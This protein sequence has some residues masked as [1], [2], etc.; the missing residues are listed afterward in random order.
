M[1]TSLQW[2]W[3]GPGILA[4]GCWTPILIAFAAEMELGWA[5]LGWA[6]RDDGVVSALIGVVP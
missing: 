4:P 2:G 3:V 1:L 6:G 5:G